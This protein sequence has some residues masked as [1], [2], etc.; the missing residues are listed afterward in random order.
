[1]LE[2]PTGIA[3]ATQVDVRDETATSN[4]TE[5]VETST[6]DEIKP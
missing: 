5:W 1:M 6:F 3:V 4:W 2:L